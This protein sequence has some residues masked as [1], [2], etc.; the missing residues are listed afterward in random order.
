MGGDWKWRRQLQRVVVPFR[1]NVSGI[2]HLVLPLISA[3]T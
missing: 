3:E 2:E 1:H